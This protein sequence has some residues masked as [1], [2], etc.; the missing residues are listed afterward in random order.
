MLCLSGVRTPQCRALPRLPGVHLVPV[1]RDG[2]LRRRRGLTHAALLST[3][4]SRP[5]LCPTRAGSIRDVL[6]ARGTPLSEPQV[7]FICRDCLNG[8]SYLHS[9]NKVHRDIKC[10]NILLS[11]SGEVKL[12]DFGVAAQLTKTISKRNTFI[13]TPHWMAPEV[14]QESRYDGKVDVWALGISAIEMA[15][16]QPPRSTVHPMRVIFMVR[17]LVLLLCSSGACV[18]E[19]FARRYRARRRRCWATRGLGAW[20]FT[21][22]WLRRV[23]PVQAQTKCGLTRHRCPQCLQKIARQRPSAAELLTHKFAQSAV[24]RICLL[25]PPCFALNSLPRRPPRA[26]CSPRLPPRAPGWPRSAATPRPP[27]TAKRFA[28]PPR[29]AHRRAAPALQPATAA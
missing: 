6:N 22:L 3:R 23:A 17:L 21:S 4:V 11:A 1:D 14:I 9:L 2:V 12:A 10:S 18:T 13:G 25:P 5:P 8:L 15:E 26:A 16:G 24:V 28:P 29:A 19:C 27:G 7:A 20:R